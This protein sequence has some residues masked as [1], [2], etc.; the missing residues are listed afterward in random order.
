MRLLTGTPSPLGATWDGL[1]VNFALFSEHAWRVEL[2]LF[3][4][5]DDAAPAVTFALPERTGP[6]WH[7]YAPSLRPGQLYGYRVHGPFEPESGHRFNPNK[8]VLDPYA[9]ALGRPIRWDNALFSYEIGHQ[10]LDLSF[11]EADSAAYAPLGLVVEE[12]FSWGDDRP[13]RV[14]W[15]DTIV[16]ETHVKGV[17]KLHPEVPEE[18][19]GTYLGLASEPIVDHLTRLG[20][21]SVELLPVQAFVND[22]HL[23]ERDLSQYWGYSPLAYFAPEPSYARDPAHAVRDFK[24]MVRALHAAGLEVFIDVV[25]NHTGEGNQLGPTLSFK[26]LDNRS[27]YKM[28][29]ENA[30]YYM[31]YTGTGNTLD[32]GHPAALTLMTDSLRYWVTEMHVDGF[33]FDLAVTLARDDF[34]V[35][36]TSGFF[37]AVAQD[38]VLSTVKLIAE[39]WDVGPNGYQVGGFPWRW[40]EWNGRYRDTVRGYWRGGGAYDDLAKRVTGSSDL[41]AYNGRKP[42]ASVNFITAHDGFTLQDLVSYER[43][44]NA[45]NGEGN[46]DGH[47]HSLSTN[48]G[49]EGPTDDPAVLERRGAL[50]RSFLTTL[51]LSQGTPMLL[52][53]DELSRTQGGNNNAYCQD[54]PISW[55]NWDLDEREE[56]FLRFTRDLIAFRKAH[57]IFRQRDFLTGA[58]E[59][60]RDSS[61][62]HPDGR[63]MWAEDWHNAEQRA[64]GLLLNGAALDCKLDKNAASGSKP[65]EEHEN[66]FFVLFHGV[67]P[68][69]FVLPPVPDAP[70]KS[71]PDLSSPD[72]E[73]GVGAAN[74]DSDFVPVHVKTDNALVWRWLWNTGV[75]RER[76][77]R[78]LTPGTRL[79]L[80][81]RQ[82]SVFRAVRQ[83]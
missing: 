48:S 14:P 43:R 60:L 38:P 69:R 53:G 15:E 45:A 40:A 56:E 16:Y 3:D 18:L 59:S 8:V 30:R 77:V 83:T 70:A 55:Y 44:H 47:A 54:N 82:M 13:P 79:V 19:R 57:P 17:S 23:V 42:A 26:G 65:G 22:R 75:G 73:L 9:K 63:E 49:V 36:M 46:R 76:R 52:G 41:F 11:S 74:I 71:P 51:F 58:G 6:V 68:S 31:D 7:G 10:D 66:T 80:K 33:R 61:W 78:T 34:N 67:R 29:P 50:K 4:H 62:W 5:P 12:A 28:S 32:V 81:A 21:T 64:L 72:S 20:V 1:G 35:A 27:Y 39:P 25:Y 37:K 24:M 2:L